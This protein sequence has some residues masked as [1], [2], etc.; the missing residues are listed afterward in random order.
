MTDDEYFKQ[1][2]KLGRAVTRAERN[3][4]EFSGSLAD[5]LHLQMKVAAAREALRLH[6]LN[7]WEPQ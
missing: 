1:A 2:E 4:R 3:F 5:K 6:R 7:R